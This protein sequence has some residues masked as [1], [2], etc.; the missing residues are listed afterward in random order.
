MGS[1]EGFG[2]GS[3][4]ARGKTERVAVPA[5]PMPLAIL[6]CILNFLVPGLGTIL[7]GFSVCCCARNED[8]S[9]CSRLGSCC[10]SFAIGILQLF[11]VALLLLGWVW[12]CMWGVFFIGMSTEYYHDNPPD[13]GP[14]ISQQP[15]PVGNMDIQAGHPIY[16]YGTQAGGYQPQDTRMYPSGPQPTVPYTQ[17]YGE[18]Q[19][20]PFYGG[21]P[22]P[23]YSERPVMPSAPPLEKQ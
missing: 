15:A 16:T 9:G 5:M 6:C 4:Q 23:P 20:P 10:I 22:P 8:M 11:T 2:E 19:Q 7:A 3:G 21:E 1:G 18:P 12:S 14:V 17:G 13:R